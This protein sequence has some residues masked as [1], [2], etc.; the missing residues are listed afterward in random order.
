M[1][2]KIKNI[3][4]AGMGYT[5]FHVKLKWRNYFEILS[6]FKTDLN[7]VSFA[8]FLQKLTMTSAQDR[9]LTGYNTMASCMELML[10]GMWDPIR[11]STQPSSL[12][13]TLTRT[14][15]SAWVCLQ[16]KSHLLNLGE[17]EFTE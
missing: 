7:F 4:P 5:T 6:L 12:M 16:K 10:P 2:I 3:L 17:L 11:R 9:I 14:L 8:E 15:S 13:M 1:H